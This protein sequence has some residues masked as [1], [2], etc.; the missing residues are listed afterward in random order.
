MI[1]IITPCSRPENLDALSK[2]IMQLNYPFTW[3]ICY[4]LRVVKEFNPVYGAT[5]Q[6]G[7]EGGVYGNLQR[8]KA[9]DYIVNPYEWIYCLDDDNTM[10][11][12]FAYLFK[13]YSLRNPDLD[14]VTFDQQLSDSV[15]LGSDIREGFIDQAQFMVRKRIIEPYEQTYSADGILI[16]KLYKKY[17]ERTLYYNEVLSY[18]NRLTW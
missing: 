10:H 4:D 18:Y 9:I 5:Y 6:I 7:I 15:R 12:D 14:I 11:P 3:I 8:N 1:T 2:S 16:E 17:P 13:Q